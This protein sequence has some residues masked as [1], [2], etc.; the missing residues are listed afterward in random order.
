MKPQEQMD[1]SF[2]DLIETIH[3]SEKVST[4]IHGLRD[5]SEILRTIKEEF[6]KS[7]RYVAT[8]L[9]LTENGASLQV[10]TSSLS[11]SILKAMEK[12]AGLSLK[13]YTID[14]KKSSI[15]SKVVKEGETLQCCGV[16]ILAELLPNRIV[17]AVA[18]IM[19]VG[20]EP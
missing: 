18:K 3:F 16:D 2:S 1:N 13:T 10:I 4:K 17:T 7:N 9:F 19:G 14:L 8:I 5:E 12:A 6:A 20:K 15:F 11:S